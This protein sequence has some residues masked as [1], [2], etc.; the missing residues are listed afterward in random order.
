MLRWGAGDTAEDLG[1]NFWNMEIGND[2]KYTTNLSPRLKA[3]GSGNL[4]LLGLNRVLRAKLGYH[5]AEEL[6]YKETK[7]TPLFVTLFLPRFSRF[8]CMKIFCFFIPSGH[9]FKMLSFF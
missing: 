5:G 7:V 3:K 6:G 1:H 8:S 4:S 2:N 9:I